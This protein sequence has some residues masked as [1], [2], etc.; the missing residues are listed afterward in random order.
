MFRSLCISALLGALLVASP[1][2]SA[3]AEAGGLV[4][5]LNKLEEIEGGCRTF[6]LFRNRT[7]RAMTGFELS[8]AILDTDGVIDRL[9]TIDAAPLPASRTT[10]KLFEIPEIGCDRIGT[11]LLHEIASCASEAGDSPDC[12]AL[13]RLESKAGVA[14]EM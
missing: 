3:R 10:L 11:I 14:L 12:F 1:T 4:V 6:F 5:E 9:L 7:A 13:I 2:E 8:L